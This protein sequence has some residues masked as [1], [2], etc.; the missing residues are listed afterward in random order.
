MGTP[1]HGC[2]PGARAAL[3]R[4]ARTDPQPDPGRTGDHRPKVCCLC[5]SKA[6]R[7][8]SSTCS[9]PSRL[10]RTRYPRRGQRNRGASTTRRSNNSRRCCSRSLAATLMRRWC[11]TARVRNAGCRTTRRCAPSPSAIGMCSWYRGGME[12][13]QHAGQQFV[14]AQRR[15]GPLAPTVPATLQDGSSAAIPICRSRR[16]VR[17]PRPK[18]TVFE[19]PQLARTSHRSRERSF[20]FCEA[21]RIPA[22]VQRQ[23][24]ARSSPAP[25]A[26]KAMKTVSS[27][28]A[29]PSS[30]ECRRERH[31][32]RHTRQTA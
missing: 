5:C 30:R 32:W 31:S 7:S 3:G 6:F 1:G 13:W 24:L 14:P 20:I 28:R 17:Y 18:P 11:S 25:T 2:A 8:T 23:S 10:C 15:L 21:K 22:I 26:Q 29:T 12:A 16:M 19:F 9:G 4:D 27:D